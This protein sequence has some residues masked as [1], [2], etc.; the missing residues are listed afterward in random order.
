MEFLL[1][2]PCRIFGTPA[3][4][5]GGGKIK[6]IEAGAYQ[7]VDCSLMAHPNPSSYLSL[8][9][10]L[11]AWAATVEYNGSEWSLE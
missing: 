10:S 4:E 5:G 8:G 6:M 3:E 7:G 11:A 2:T 9:S 1:R